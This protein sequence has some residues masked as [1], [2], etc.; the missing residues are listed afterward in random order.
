ME[1]EWDPV[2]EAI[3]FEKHGIRFV[4]ASTVFEDSNARVF[5]DPKHSLSE[6]REI[7]VG[8]SKESRVL[9]VSFTER[10]PRIRIISARRANRKERWEHEE[11]KQ[12]RSQK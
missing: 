7:L 3:N 4:E 1:F 6:H 2:K 12:S 9:V 8:A 10:E 5:Q 11:Y